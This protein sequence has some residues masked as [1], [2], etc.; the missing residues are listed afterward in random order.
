LREAFTAGAIIAFDTLV[1]LQT[2]HAT[3]PRFSCP[4]LALEF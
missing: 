3:K 1:E 2:G 4:S